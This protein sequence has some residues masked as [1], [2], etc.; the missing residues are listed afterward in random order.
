MNHLVTVTSHQQQI[1]APA[2][3]PPCPCPLAACPCCS[4]RVL[5][6][7]AARLSL[8]T[9]SPISQYSMKVKVHIL[10]VPLAPFAANSQ[11][12]MALGEAHP[13]PPPVEHPTM[14]AWR[15]NDR[16]KCVIPFILPLSQPSPASI[17]TGQRQGAHPRKSQRPSSPL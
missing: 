4:R 14:A 9:S 16:R 5:Q 7:L 13:R 2:N 10:L 6:R 15:G 8:P 12:E 1:I 17:S 11:P 3:K